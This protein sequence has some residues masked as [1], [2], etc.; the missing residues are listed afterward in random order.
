MKAAGWDAGHHCRPGTPEFWG[1]IESHWRGGRGWDILVA[2]MQAYSRP[3]RATLLVRV[4]WLT[5]LAFSGSS[6]RLSAAQ[7]PGLVPVGAPWRYLPATEEPTVPATA[8]RQVDFDDAEWLTG[9]S[10]FTMATDE[11]TQ[12][13][14]SAAGTVYF[15]HLFTVADPQWIQWL[16]L[17]VDYSDGFVAYLNGTE[18]ARRGV[19]VDDPLPFGTLAGYHAHG[20]TEEIKVT[21]CRSLLV[22]GTNVL[23]IQLHSYAWPPPHYILVPELLANFARGPLVR[24][25]TG[26]RAEIVWHTPEALAGAVDYG[27]TEALGFSVTNAVAAREQVLRLNNLPPGARCFYRAR[28]VG[29]DAQ[30][31][32][33]VAS[34]RTAPAGGDLSFGVLGDTGGGR[35]PQ[36]RVAS[37]LATSA[38]DVVVH[39][40]DVIYP[41]FTAEQVD[42]RCFSIYGLHMRSVPY[43][44]VFG[45]HDLYGGSDRPFLQAFGPP[46]NSATGTG[47]YFAFDHG[48]AHFVCLF[49]PLLSFPGGTAGYSLAPGGTQW[50]WLTNDLARTDRPWKI[51]FLHCPLFTSS[52]HRTDDYNYNTIPDRLELQSWLLPVAAKYGVQ[53]IF[54]GHDHTYERFAPTNGVHCYVSGGGGY[55]LYALYQR[56]DLSQCFASRYHHL[57]ATVRGEHME[58]EA[59][60]EFGVRLDRSLVP[61]GISVRVERAGWGRLRVVWTALPGET[62]DLEAAPAVGGPFQTVVDPTLPRVA[63]STEEALELPPLE[64]GTPTQFFRVRPRPRFN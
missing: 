18:I 45:N 44:F 28:A 64:P 16:A 41:L 15:R 49:A 46:T 63:T 57:R 13:P 39:V 22:A 40:G 20:A 27:P 14:A 29:V 38:V 11:A 42:A 19:P 61:R 55:N 59:V 31:E 54:A 4:I 9:V 8:W 34:F 33:P 1:G 56:D 30:A 36:Y 43:Y 58:V 6:G 50:N 3:L 2:F 26:E 7:E 32:A 52:L 51:L 60:D 48:D 12:M 47:H 10:G 35:V 5:I 21:A 62:Y 24:N 53:A 17:R 23:A 25:V 37:G